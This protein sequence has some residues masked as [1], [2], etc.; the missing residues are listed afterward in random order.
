MYILSCV[1][2]IYFVRFGVFMF[3]FICDS[4]SHPRHLIIRLFRIVYQN[5]CIIKI[6]I[7]RTTG[8]SF[9]FTLNVRTLFFFF[10]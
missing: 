8:L 5:V 3:Y 4:S 6:E 10:F 2:N 1:F 9:S 7:L